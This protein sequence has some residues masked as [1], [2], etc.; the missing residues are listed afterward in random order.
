MNIDH[1]APNTF[2]LRLTSPEG[3]EVNILQP[4]TN[5]GVNPGDRYFPIG[6]NA[7]YGEE[8]TGTWT[9]EV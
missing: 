8:M 1:A 2:G 6:V 7:F 5:L 4:Y 9:L 3:T